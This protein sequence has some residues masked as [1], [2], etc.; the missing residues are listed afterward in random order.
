MKCHSE[1]SEESRSAR[2]RPSQKD[3]GEIP[4][5]ARND[6]A[7]QSR[8]RT[9]ENQDS[10]LATSLQP[11]AFCLLPT[12]YCLLLTAFCLLFFADPPFP[13]FLAATGL[14]E[15]QNE[16]SIQADLRF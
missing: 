10:I 5:F 15:R 11:R 8:K 6:S 1:R 3:Q 12:A 2:G 13:E 16:N 7:F 9:L 14:I 4:R